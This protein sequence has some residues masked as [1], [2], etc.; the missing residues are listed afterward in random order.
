MPATSI[1]QACQTQAATKAAYRVLANDAVA[2]GAIITAHAKK[3]AERIS[4]QKVVI[5]AHDT[6]N[7]DLSSHKKAQNIGYLDTK[8]GRGIKL[9]TS[10]AISEKGVPQ[11]ILCQKAWVR[12]DDEYGK[13]SDRAKK[14]VEEK[15]SYRWIEGMRSARDMAPDGVSLIHI[16]DR[17][18]DIYE[19]INE[20]LS[21]NNNYPLIRACHDRQVMTSDGANGHL[22][23]II[24][25]S[26][27]RCEMTVSIARRG[28][29]RHP[30]TVK[31][32]VRYMPVTLLPPSGKKDLKLLK[33]WVISVTEVT[34]GQGG[35]NWILLSGI[36]VN[37][38]ADAII[39]VSYY[40]MRW[41]IERFHYTLKIGCGVEELQLEESSRLM[42]AIELYSVVAF[43]ILWIAYESRVNSGGS[44]G[45]ILSAMELKLLMILLLSSG[46]RRVAVPE[47]IGECV[48]LIALL[49]GFLGRKS[50]GDP[51]VKTIWRGMSRL[52][53]AVKTARAVAEYGFPDGKIVGN[54]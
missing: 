53:D 2:P 37:S 39:M 54:G 9:H 40:S 16:A 45:I 7:V 22:F 4:T 3:T 12:N 33:L 46:H 10:L 52:E 15:E 43:R 14:P 47:T 8:Y 25:D 49:G 24:A 26:P 41:L 42:R 21:L 20:T 27:L 18:S 50:D 17:E 29:E 23:K 31:C 48:R 28:K 34:S 35:I 1:P 32:E 19:F 5:V 11:G 30:E 13:K 36:P 6:S 51:G 38:N 44:S